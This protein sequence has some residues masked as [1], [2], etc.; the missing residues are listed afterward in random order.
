MCSPLQGSIF[1]R[2]DGW[3]MIFENLRGEGANEKLD[4]K[5][6]VLPK[7]SLLYP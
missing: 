5:G 6:Q 1:L 2:I 7:N 4:M 3:E